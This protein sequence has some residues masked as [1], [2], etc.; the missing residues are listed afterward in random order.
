[1]RQPVLADAGFE[2]L[3]EAVVDA[4]AWPN[5]GFGDRVGHADRVTA[6]DGSQRMCREELR[7]LGVAKLS[8]QIAEAKSD[9]ILANDCRKRCL[10]SLA[11]R[12]DDRAFD[13]A[14]AEKRQ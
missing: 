4:I 8:V 2:R 13:Q 6:D 9:P 7:G 11:E 12:I 10:L 3:G 5:L 14:R 1:M